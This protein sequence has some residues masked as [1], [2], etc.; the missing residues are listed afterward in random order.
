MCLESRDLNF[1]LNGQQVVFEIRSMSEFAPRKNE[2]QL[3]NI[4]VLP[5]G[6]MCVMRAPSYWKLQAYPLGRADGGG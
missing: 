3:G 5:M 1:R 6:M 4:F 2:S